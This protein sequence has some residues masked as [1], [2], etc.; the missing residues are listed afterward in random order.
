MV[1]TQS[2]QIVSKELVPKF[3]FLL[4]GHLD[5]SHVVPRTTKEGAFLPFAQEIRL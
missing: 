4:S 2:T 3:Y 5:L 1:P